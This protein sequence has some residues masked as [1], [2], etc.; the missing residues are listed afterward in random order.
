MYAAMQKAFAYYR[1]SNAHMDEDNQESLTRQQ[2]A[3]ERYAKQAGFD[4]VDSVY[5]AAV[6]GAD[7]IDQRPGFAEALKRIAANGVR[8]IIVKQPPASPVT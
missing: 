1:T 8:T 2:V 3:V 4:I 6:S 5:D 7:P